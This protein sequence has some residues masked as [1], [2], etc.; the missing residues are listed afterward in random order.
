[1]RLDLEG[2]TAGYGS[3]VVV[4]DVSLSVPAGQVVALLGAN[5]AG[6]TSLLKVVSGLLRPYAGQV[7][8]DGNDVTATRSDARA[9]LGVCH[10]TEGRSIFPH[11]SVDDNVRLFTPRGAGAA[12]VDAALDCFPVLRQFSSRPAGSLSGG[13]QQMLALVRAYLTGAPLVLFDE[14]SMG[15]API[16][17]D[18]I[19]GFLARLRSAGTSLLVVEQYIPKALALADVVYILAKGRIVFAGE[20]G[21]LRGSAEIM[22]HYF[23]AAANGR[24][25]TRVS[26]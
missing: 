24:R 17:V 8:V 1:V 13:Q 2:V 5:G 15:L 12:E 11:L 6:K 14:I 10:I 21:E 19:F 7:L 18:E 22:E 23:N 4:R 9:R 25:P 20:P 26:R 16:V 3:T